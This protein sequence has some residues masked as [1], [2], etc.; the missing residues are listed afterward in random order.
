MYLY[1]HNIYFEGKSV[2]NERKINIYK[3]NK[4]RKIST[5]FYKSKHEK[6]FL[7][8][9]VNK[10]NIVFASY[11]ISNV[12]FDEQK[13][14]FVRQSQKKLIAVNSANEICVSSEEPTYWS[15]DPDLEIFPS[16]RAYK[17]REVWIII[18][19][20]AYVAR[21]VGIISSSRAY[22]RGEIGICP[23]PKVSIQGKKSE[24]LQVSRP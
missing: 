17:A 12:Y 13:Y 14:S 3:H 8:M 24:I 7:D 10:N 15:T 1:V 11:K 5:F 22:V 21:G 16:P 18:S 6:V 2:F 4:N 20:G 9:F 19:P 23:I